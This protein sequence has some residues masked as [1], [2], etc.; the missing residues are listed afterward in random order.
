MPVLPSSDD[1]LPVEVVRRWLLQ[2]PLLFDVLGRLGVALVTWWRHH[3]SL[4]V[5]ALEQLVTPHLTCGGGMGVVGYLGRGHRYCNG[6]LLLGL[7][8]GGQQAI[9]FSRV[10]K[11]LTVP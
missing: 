6:C 4:G 7:I 10:G 3:A 2:T 1:A 11:F 5:A 9:D 8:P